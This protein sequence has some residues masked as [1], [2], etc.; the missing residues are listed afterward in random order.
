MGMTL[1]DLTHRET[2]LDNLAPG[3]VFRD[4]ENFDFWLITTKRNPALVACINLA[5]G[6][7]Q[8]FEVTSKVEPLKAELVIRG[9]ES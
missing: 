1:N 5:T 8:D 6:E 3:S 4:F 7:V 9:I 2:P